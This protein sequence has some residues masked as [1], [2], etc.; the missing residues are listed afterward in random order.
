MYVHTLVEAFPE[1]VNARPGEIQ[2]ESLTELRNLVVVDNAE[3]HEGHFQVADTRSII[4]WKEILMWRADVCESEIQSEIIRGQNEDE[5][6]NLQFTRC[7][8]R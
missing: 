8:S 7:V 6:I 5:V 3:E 1:I 2:I 4:A